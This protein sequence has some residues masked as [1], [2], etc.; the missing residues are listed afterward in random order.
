VQG[1]STDFLVFA[2]RH[3]SGPALTLVVADMADVRQVQF[4]QTGTASVTLRVVAGNNYGE[5]TKQE[6]RRRLHQYLGDSVSM[7]IEE[8]ASVLSEASGK[9]RFVINEVVPGA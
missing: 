5:S 4:V 3:I 8:T 9:Y 6:L 2:D 1:R 7:Q